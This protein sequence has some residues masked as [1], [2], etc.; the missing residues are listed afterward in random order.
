MS[1]KLTEEQIKDIAKRNGLEYAALRAVI[2]VEGSGKGFSDATGK[3][4]VQ[5]EP[6]HFQKYTGHRLAN[7]VENQTKEWEAFNRAFAINKDAAM[8]S[9][10]I[11]M[12]QVMGFHAKL[13][14]FKTVGEMWDFAK[15]S[16][17]NQVELGLRFIKSNKKL[18]DALKKKDWP[19]FAKFYNGAQY[20]KFAYDTRMAKAYEKYA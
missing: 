16:E 8:M 1:K 2:E 4:L 18:Y 9:T 19:T 13:L 5:F 14:G 20:K 12:M 10:S 17:A 15:V 11:G 7:G 6:F 3:I